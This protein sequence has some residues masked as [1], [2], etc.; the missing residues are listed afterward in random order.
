MSEY[1]REWNRLGL[2]WCL[3]VGLEGCCCTD[4]ERWKELYGCLWGDRG[5]GPGEAAGD[6]VLR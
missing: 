1:L 5:E 3:S 6:T 2:L 4:M